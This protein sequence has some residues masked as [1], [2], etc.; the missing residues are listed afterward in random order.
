MHIP[1][2]GKRQTGMCSVSVQTIL[3]NVNDY[4]FVRWQTF[5]N[6][7][8]LLLLPLSVRVLYLVLVLIYSKHFIFERKT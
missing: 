5:W 1:S 4:F 7:L 8:N 2:G 3:S 6:S